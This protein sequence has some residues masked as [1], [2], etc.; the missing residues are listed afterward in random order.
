MKNILNLVFMV[1]T[2]NSFAQTNREPINMNPYP[3]QVKI[4]PIKRAPINTN[5]YP[6]QTLE[7]NPR[8]E[9]GS[10]SKPIPV[11]VQE[12]KNVE[13]KQNTHSAAY[14]SPTLVQQPENPQTQSIHSSNPKSATYVNENIQ[15]KN[16][17]M[18]KKPTKVFRNNKSAAFSE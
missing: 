12:K 10:N 14:V 7:A 3:N 13:V 6:N 17:Q 4:E 18:E 8:G 1:L 16:A 2:F 9:K 15:K 5:A 11:V